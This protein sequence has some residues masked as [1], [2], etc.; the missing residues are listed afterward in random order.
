MKGHTII[1]SWGLLALG[2]GFAAVTAR[3]IF[4]DVFT[5][6]A[7][8]TI[9][10]L[11]SAAAL[12]AA[13]ASGH[14]AWPQLKQAHIPAALGLAVI[15]IAATGYIVATSGSRNAEAM[16]TKGAAILKTNE[17]RT[18]LRAKVFEVEADL[19]D[20]KQEYELAKAEAA[21]ECG[22]GKKT[23]CE[24]KEA[25]RENA[26]KDLERAEAL[27]SMTRGKLSLLGPEQQPNA[28]Y[29]QAAKV[30]EA[31][32]I[33]KA[34]EIEARLIL[35]LPFLTVFISEACTLVFV[36]MGIGHNRQTI[37]ATPSTNMV[38]PAKA[39]P[40]IPAKHLPAKASSVFPGKRGRKQDQRV[41]D[42]S[43]TFSRTHGRTPTGAEIRAQFPDL[44]RS[45]AY[46][47]SR[48][49]TYPGRQGSP[50]RLV[51]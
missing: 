45:T 21:K 28:G 31:F 11:N 29:K 49:A 43:D 41:I 2:L 44:P 50:L 10:H 37:H 26:A 20:T 30:A 39:L 48:K 6:T 14:M 42:F 27:A 33:G 38:S 51:S 46:D 5:G 47:Y 36:S 35:I 12:V 24:G 22:T 8:I 19:S 17:E 18:A 25:T 32:G 3:T 15:F 16:Q 1:R 7:P 23:R 34:D 4:D 40:A 13:I 9:A